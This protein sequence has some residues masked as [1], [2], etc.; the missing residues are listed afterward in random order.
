ML[1][2]NYITLDRWMDGKEVAPED[3]PYINENLYPMLMKKTPCID[4]DLHFMLMNTYTLY[5][6]KP[7]SCIDE[8]LY[9][10]LM[11]AYTLCWWTPIAYIDENQYLILMNI[12]ILYWWKPM[13]ILMK[14]YSLCLWTPIIPYIDE[15]IEN[16]WLGNIY[17]RY[18][19]KYLARRGFAQKVFLL[20]DKNCLKVVDREAEILLYLDNCSQKRW[21][22]ILHSRQISAWQRDGAV[23]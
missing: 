5:R 14:S 20:T 13:S 19:N 1:R 23:F 12:Y 11:K 10:I 9:P 2:G 16:M 17:S 6:W 7:I 22:G 8:I 21:R 3:W 15:N 4:E 18:I